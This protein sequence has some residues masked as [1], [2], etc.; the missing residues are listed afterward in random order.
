MK[1]YMVCYD[2]GNHRRLAKL[3]R[4]LE[5][6]AMRIQKSVFLL[7]SVT[8]EQLLDIIEMINAIIDSEEDDVR[9]YTVIDPGISLA[10]AVNLSDPYIFLD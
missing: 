10:Q 3:A 6:E 7:S 1:D 5:K 9:I 4:N 2:I 8:N